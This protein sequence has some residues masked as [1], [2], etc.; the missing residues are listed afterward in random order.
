MGKP[1]LLGIL[2]VLG[3]I[4]GWRYYENSQKLSTKASLRIYVESFNQYRK[5]ENEM[6]AHIIAQGHYGGT[7][8]QT[9]TEPLVR[10]V[11]H[12]REKDGCPRIPDKA[13]Q[14]K[15]DGL[16][17]Q[18]QKSLSDLQTQGFSR[19]VGEPLK[20]I[21]SSVH[22]FT[23]EDVTNKYPDIIKKTEMTP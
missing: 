16:F 15:C 7:I 2:L 14:Q 11:Q 20:D 5:I 8:P 23:S 12:M 22:R 9:L 13:L 1:V 17:A 3:G 18:Y 10:E 6:L 21:I 4:L 19:S